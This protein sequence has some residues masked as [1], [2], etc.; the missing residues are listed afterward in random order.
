MCALAVELRVTGFKLH[1]HGSTLLLMVNSNR[2]T[3]L[4]RQSYHWLGSVTLSDENSNRILY[5][6][7]TS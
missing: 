5:T 4:G 3:C 7:N 6:I 1:L 2:D